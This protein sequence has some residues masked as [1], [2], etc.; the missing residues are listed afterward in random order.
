MRGILFDKDGTLLD[1]EATWTPILH[2]LALEAAG[3]D[4]GRA[5]QLLVAGGFLPETGKYQAGSVLAAG[6]SD[7]VALLFYPGLSEAAQIERIAHIDRMFHD[8][9]SVNSVVLDGVAETL[10]DLAGLGYIMGVATHDATEASKAALAAVGM[11]QHL[12]HIFG[13]DAV[14][15]RKPAPDLVHLFC[16][17]SGL[18]PAEVVVVGDNVHDLGMARSAGAV[19]VG[20]TSG[21][22][23]AEELAPHADAVLDS[24][25]D[26]PAWLHQN[27]K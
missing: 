25:C 18:T 7:A 11:A 6:A 19:A 4:D 22:S 21:N 8:H 5:T 1:F 17:A 16:A 24:V 2:E 13:Y 23:S 15:N 10:V 3:G 14:A 27:R 12:P 20:V 9:G 26:L